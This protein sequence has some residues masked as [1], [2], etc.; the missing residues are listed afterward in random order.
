MSRG[1][2]ARRG[3]EPL[4]SALRGQRPR[5]LD[6]RAARTRLVN[7][8]ILT[9]WRLSRPLVLLLLLASCA[10]IQKAFA[11]A[12]YPWPL[13]RDHRVKRDGLRLRVYGGS[14]KSQNL[15]A[16]DAREALR[17]YLLTLD[18]PGE[19]EQR[20]KRV[21]SALRAFPALPTRTAAAQGHAAV[22]DIELSALQAVLGT[23]YD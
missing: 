11:P 9:V 1:L 18:I 21:N 17:R 3:F 7:K 12:P 8:A 4:I 16:E 5:P 6:E 22:I 19:P 23:R 2:V 20:Q 13:P 15:A 10:Q 14:F